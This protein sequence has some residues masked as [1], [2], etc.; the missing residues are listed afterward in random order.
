MLDR[1]VTLLNRTL[2]Q[3]E[4]IELK[5]AI[6]VSTRRK[7]EA[8]WQTRAQNEEMTLLSRPR[9]RADYVRRTGPSQ[10]NCRPREPFIAG[11]KSSILFQKLKTSTQRQI[12]FGLAWLT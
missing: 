11:Y 8:F 1:K 10:R 9:T 12:H 5:R 2:V 7:E 3:R 4:S 6:E